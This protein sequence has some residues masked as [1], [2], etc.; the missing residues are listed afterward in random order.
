MKKTKFKLVLARVHPKNA[1][2]RNQLSVVPEA[3]FE[4]EAKAFRLDFPKSKLLLVTDPKHAFSDIRLAAD[5]GASLLIEGK[6]KSPRK[7]NEAYYTLRLR[8]AGSRERQTQAFSEYSDHLLERMPSTDVYEKARSRL[9]RALEQVSPVLSV[10]LKDSFL[11]IFDNGWNEKKRNA[12]LLV[13]VD[14]CNPAIESVITDPDIFKEMLSRVP[15]VYVIAAPM[16]W[17]KTSRI[18][19]P[20]FEE[21]KGRGDLPVLAVPRQSHLYSYRHKAEHYQNWWGARENSCDGL[22]AVTNS[23]FLSRRFQTVRERTRAILF[24]E[25]EL[26]RS[27]HVGEAIGKG[28]LIDRAAI[29]SAEE[30]LVRTVLDER[31]GT[32]VYVDALL[33]D[34]TLSHIAKVTGRKV[35]LFQPETTPHV[36]NLFVYDSRE[37]LVDRIR[38]MLKE[39]KNVAVISDIAHKDLTNDKLQALHENLSKCCREKEGVLLDAQTFPDLCDSGELNKLDATLEKH[40]LITISPVL[41]TAAS[42][43]TTHFHAVFVIGSGTMPPNELLQCFRRFRAVPDV[44]LSLPARLK[45]VTRSEAQL[46]CEE[47]AWM[48]ACEEARFDSIVDVRALPGVDSLL[49]RKLQE[50]SLRLNY[51]NKTLIMAESLGYRIVRVGSGKR[52]SGQ[53]DPLDSLIVNERN[54]EKVVS[55]RRIES[56]EASQLRQG[57]IGL[58]EESRFEMRSFELRQVFGEALSVQLVL[59]DCNGKLRRWI[60]IFGSLFDGDL[61]S[62]PLAFKLKVR[63]LEKLCLF[64]RFDPLNVSFTPLDNGLRATKVGFLRTDAARFR[65]WLSDGS[66]NVPDCGFTCMEAFGVAFPQFSSLPKSSVTLAKTLLSNELGFCVEDSKSRARIEGKDY[67]AY[68]VSQTDIQKRYAQYF[69]FK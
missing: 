54:A 2:Y 31:R 57:R 13:S 52:S 37:G 43:T 25:Y 7:A 55:A 53:E 40:Q 60:K 69:C 8:H 63:I 4:D 6:V 12:T 42:L 45:A 61:A 1:T 50:Q 36:G 10:E 32:V 39:N 3:G 14:R 62:E 67:W 58:S 47:F 11:S 17:G 66:L 27:H 34:A 16:G 59:D 35:T 24:D 49:Q 33:S 64:L 65:A 48:P 51:R 28:S 26:I 46:L 68:K 30:G 29:I 38:G 23:L 20:L 56:F 21:L 19:L 41:S 9:C 44:H 5:L 15:G 22:M 18:L